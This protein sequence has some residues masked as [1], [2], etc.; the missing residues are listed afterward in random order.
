MPDNKEVLSKIKGIFIYLPVSVEMP[1]IKNC[2]SNI[3]HLT[4]K[5]FSLGI[6]NIVTTF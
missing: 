6:R 5:E 1:E 2:V 4:E 3:Y